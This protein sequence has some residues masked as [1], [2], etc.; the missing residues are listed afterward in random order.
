MQTSSF[1]SSVSIAYQWR[2]YLLVRKFQQVLRPLYTNYTAIQI[3]L[4][5]LVS[6]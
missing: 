5:V 1:E 6:I 4:E 2:S 3:L